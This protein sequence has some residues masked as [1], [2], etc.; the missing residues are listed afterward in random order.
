VSAK[1][2]RPFFVFAAV[3][4]IC[5]MV[6]ITGLSKAEDSRAPRHDSGNIAAPGGTISPSL[7]SS[8]SPGSG[9]G[10]GTDADTASGSKDTSDIWG[11]SAS[12]ARPG[13]GPGEPDSG[14]SSLPPLIDL[15]NPEFDLPETDIDELDGPPLDDGTSHGPRVRAGHGKDGKGDE[16]KGD[17]TKDDETGDDEADDKGDGD[18]PDDPAESESDEVPADGLPSQ[19]ADEIEVPATGD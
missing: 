12:G 5:S 2:R 1:H 15:T 6:L 11:P 14:V 9:A 10:P 19:S 16:A 13:G 7:D 8:G 3:A 4:L 18:G 17:Q